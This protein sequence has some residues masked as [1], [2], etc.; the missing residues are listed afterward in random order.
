MPGSARPGLRPFRRPLRRSASPVFAAGVKAFGL[1]GSRRLSSS[2]YYAPLRTGRRTRFRCRCRSPLRCARP[3]VRSA[4]RADRSR[5]ASFLARR[6][7]R[8]ARV[9]LV[10]SDA[11][12]APCVVGL[13][14]KGMRRRRC[15]S[16]GVGYRSRAMGGA[17]LRLALATAGAPSLVSAP[18]ARLGMV[19]GGE[20]QPSGSS[21]EVE[22]F[23][24]E[25]LCV[26]RGASGAGSD[27]AARSR[28]AV[29][30]HLGPQW[31]R[32]QYGSPGGCGGFPSRVS[33]G[34]PDRR[35]GG[36]G[37]QNGI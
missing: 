7:A 13:L 35:G 9:L 28:R 20:I 26:G 21:R 6:S 25:G 37:G 19:S 24:D 18:S 34:S 2:R 17:R 22:G 11:A 32:E 12:S 23:P 10:V 33:A 4:P 5:P 31:C 15:G 14:N 16:S 3:Y 27:G 1:V 29:E 8:P 30:Y 36:C